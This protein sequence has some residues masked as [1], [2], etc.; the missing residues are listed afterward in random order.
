MLPLLIAS[1]LEMSQLA[2]PGSTHTVTGLS[3]SISSANTQLLLP[4]PS[5]AARSAAQGNC[6]MGAQE[7]D[8]NPVVTTSHREPDIFSIS[9]NVS[10][11][12]A[13]QYVSERSLYTYPVLIPFLKYSGRQDPMVDGSLVWSSAPGFVF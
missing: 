1:H 7:T 6:V 3:T 5:N 4:S 12:V 10:T 8:T 13:R 2:V 9:R 11:V